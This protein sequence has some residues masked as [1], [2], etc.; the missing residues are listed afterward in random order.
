MPEVPSLT[1]RTLQ[2][3]DAF[4]ADHRRLTLS[5]IARRS[6]LALTTCHRIVGD[7]VAW[8]ALERGR[9]GRYGVGL[10]LWEI[11]ALAPRAVPL[12]EAALPY[13]EDLYEATHE[14]VQLAVREGLELVYIERIAGRGAVPVLTRVGGRFAMHATGVGLVLLAHAPADI[15]DA[16]LRSRLQAWTPRTITDPA[17]L[18]ATLAQVR[19][20][21][22]ATSRGQVT[23]DALS[24]ACPVRGPEGEVVAAVSLVVH[25]DT[26]E[27]LRLLPALRA[28]ALGISRRLG[29]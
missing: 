18:R 7:L 4:D 14:N 22:Y 6:G 3:L 2:V 8:G 9:D 26:A 10:R 11:A 28:A 12:R 29:G 20:E 21:G 19:R 17:R 24:L 27:P 15:Q 13:L 5:T 16:V 25:V 23:L 1:T